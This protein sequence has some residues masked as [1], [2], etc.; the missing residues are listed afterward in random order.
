MLARSWL[1]KFPTEVLTKVIK[2]IKKNPYSFFL[3]ATSEQE[4]I[5]TVLK[6][7][8]KLSTDCHDIDMT[9]VKW[10]INNI[11]KPLT[12]ICNISFQS[13]RFPNKMKIAKVIP[14]YKNES[15]HS[16]TN[17]RPISLLPQFSKI[18]EKLFNSRLENFLNKHQIIIQDQY[19]FRA[20]QPPQWQ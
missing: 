8:S 18:L 15:K 5:N 17:Y 2:T 4:V 20:K 11:A 16:Y 12:H 10:F 9:I 19:G 1:H 13:G 14:L 3:S 6:C 7:K